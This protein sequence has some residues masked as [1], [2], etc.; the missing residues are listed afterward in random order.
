MVPT[1]S[2]YESGSISRRLSRMSRMG[3]TSLR[4]ALYIPW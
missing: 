3:H 1:P 2:L 4:Y